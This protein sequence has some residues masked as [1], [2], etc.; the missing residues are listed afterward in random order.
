MSCRFDSCLAHWN[1]LERRDVRKGM[2]DDLYGP[3]NSALLQ[4]NAANRVRFTASLVSGHSLVREKQGDAWKADIGARLIYW[5]LSNPY[6]PEQMLTEDE[7]RWLTIHEA[8]HLELTGSWDIPPKTEID[9]EKNFFRFWNGA[10][11]IRIERWARMKFPGIAIDCRGVHASFDDLFKDT[12]EDTDNPGLRLADQAMFGFINTE[13]DIPVWMAESIVDRFWPEMDYIISTSR[14]SAE[15]AERI[16]PIYK[17]LLEIE[18]GIDGDEDP[19]DGEGEAAGLMTALLGGTSGG[20]SGGGGDE[21]EDPDAPEKP[22]PV[23]D[24]QY[25]SSDKD[26]NPGR[27]LGFLELLEGLAEAADDGA[28]KR[29][30]QDLARKEAEAEKIADRQAARGIGTDASEIEGTSNDWD[31]VKEENRNDITL[32]ARHLETKLERNQSEYWD[33]HLK[34]G[35][36]HSKLAHKSMMGDMRVFRKKE[37]VGRSDY[38]FLIT[39]DM[40]DSQRSRVSELIS[41]CVVASEAIEKCGMGLGLITWD[42]KMRHFKK[43]N[44]PLRSAKGMIGYD[45]AHAGGG[46]IEPYALRVAEDMLRQRLRLKRDCFLITLTDGQTNRLDESVQIIQDLEKA[47]VHTIGIGCACAPPRHYATKIRVD[48]PTE[49]V[50]VLPNLLRDILR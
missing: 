43:F 1:T 21:E 27:A 5:R 47:G 23:P 37:L 13:N 11:D 32:L 8:S 25:R 45:L 29:S 31:R 38:D 22:S 2:H 6:K 10:E 44:S 34:K 14:S 49:L 30:I 18:G 3:F 46:T 19:E 20:E 9:S 28:D 33:T 16:L 42:A 40:S 12:I 4:R 35:S 48:T 41:T 24:D 7:M 36:F 39:V 15:L 17:M 50:T 26:G